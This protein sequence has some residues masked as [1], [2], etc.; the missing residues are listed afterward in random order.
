MN[1]NARRSAT[2]GSFA[3]VVEDDIDAKK[4]KGKIEKS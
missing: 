2:K 1:G 4:H 3:A